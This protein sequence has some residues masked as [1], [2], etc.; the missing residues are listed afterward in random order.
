MGPGEDRVSSY[1]LSR[2]GGG[3]HVRKRRSRLRAARPND[4]QN[5]P[6]CPLKYLI[7]KHKHELKMDM[8]PRQTDTQQKCRTQKS[9]DN[10]TKARR[11][12]KQ[13]T[14]SICKHRRHLSISPSKP[15]SYFQT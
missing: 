7:I 1:P 15:P 8:N 6:E 9:R 2:S 13:Y 14:K 3:C 11:Q 12:N 10:P 4:R 5:E